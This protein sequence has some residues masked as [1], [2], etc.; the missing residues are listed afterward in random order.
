ML[1]FSNPTSPNRMWRG[2][3]T[4]TECATAGPGLARFETRASGP[5]KAYPS[6]N[7]S[8][9]IRAAQEGVEL[10]VIKSNAHNAIG[11]ILQVLAVRRDDSSRGG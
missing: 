8:S 7:H 5:G 9:G 3:L 10:R 1:P 4:C 11:H 6:P 2:R